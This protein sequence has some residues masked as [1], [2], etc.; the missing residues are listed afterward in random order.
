MILRKANAAAT[1]FRSALL[2]LLPA[3]WRVQDV[4]C[5]TGAAKQMIKASA[6][7]DFIKSHSEFVTPD[8]AA[9]VEKMRVD[10]RALGDTGGVH[11]QRRALELR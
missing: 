7:R 1:T 5:C 11:L 2:V 8:P 3:G 4:L 6:R 9:V 10:R